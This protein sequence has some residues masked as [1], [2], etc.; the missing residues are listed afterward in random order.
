MNND[1]AISEAKANPQAYASLGVTIA[2][3]LFGLFFA[4]FLEGTSLRVI[5]GTTGFILFITGIIAHSYFKKKERQVGFEP[6]RSVRRAIAYAFAVFAIC[7]LCL[8][9]FALA[10]GDFAVPILA[11][12]FAFGIFP[13]VRSLLSPDERKG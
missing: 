11:I 9:A 6:S 2:G 4:V 10:H 1:G 8:G 12:G 7:S 3:G 5:L 13:L